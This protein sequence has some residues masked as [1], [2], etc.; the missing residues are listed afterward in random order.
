[1]RDLRLE[2]VGAAGT[3]AEALAEEKDREP[4][5]VVMNIRVPGKGR[6]EAPREIAAPLYRSE[7]T[8]RNDLSS[9]HGKLGFSH[10]SQAP[11]YPVEHGLAAIG[12]EG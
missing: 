6:N 10:R 11:A 4:D 3:A 12:Q 1:V 7:K 9:I 8:V 2:F 5:I